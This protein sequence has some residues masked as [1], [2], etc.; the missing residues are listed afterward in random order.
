VIIAISS[1]VGLLMGI[2]VDL[3]I[4]VRSSD[5]LERPL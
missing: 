2:T 1:G 5:D 3:S 4:V